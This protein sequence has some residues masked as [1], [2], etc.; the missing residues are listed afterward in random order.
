MSDL[1]KLAEVTKLPCP[2]CDENKRLR[3]EAVFNTNGNRRFVYCAACNTNGPWSTPERSAEEQ[4]NQRV[5]LQEVETLRAQAAKVR[6]EA[7]EEAAKVCD[8]HA[9]EYGAINLDVTDEHRKK[10]YAAQVAL[11]SASAV[12]RALKQHAGEV[13]QYVRVPREPTREMLW[14]LCMNDID[15]QKCPS[16]VQTHYGPGTAMCLVAAKDM[17]KA[18]LAALEDGETKP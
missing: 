17:Y 1:K 4:W 13:P 12:I 3:N 8:K 7:L 6:Q 11:E 14:A 16:T 9:I 15:C 2:F 10:D 5:L 18:M